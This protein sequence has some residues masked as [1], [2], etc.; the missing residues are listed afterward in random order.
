MSVRLTAF[1]PDGPAQRAI[2]PADGSIVVGR[3]DEADFQIPHSSVSRSHLRLVAQTDGAW[4]IQDLGSKNGVQL[5]GRLINEA[6]FGEKAWLSLGDAHI[7]VEPVAPGEAEIVAKATHE[8][9]DFSE[10]VRHTIELGQ[11]TL[12]VFEALSASIISLSSCDRCSIWLAEEGRTPVLAFRDGRR[13]PKESS[14]AI[15][16]TLEQNTEIISNDVEGVAALTGRESIRLGGVRA[17]VCL[18]LNLSGG[19]SGAVYADS[20]KPGKYFSQLD[21]DLLRGVASHAALT[22]SGLRLRNEIAELTAQ[23]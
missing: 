22:L 23:H 11:T 19:A 12:E 20:L 13:T 21:V 10:K 6:H 18:P 2:F 17:L 8:R 1:L 16:E 4:L 7:L 3:G 15:R 5:D 14:T 9:T